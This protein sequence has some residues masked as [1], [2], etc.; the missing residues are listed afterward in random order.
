MIISR[1]NLTLDPFQL[2]MHLSIVICENWMYLFSQHMFE[3]N[4][5]HFTLN[6]DKIVVWK[7][8][9]NDRKNKFFLQD[10]QIAQIVGAT[11]IW[12]DTQFAHQ[13]SW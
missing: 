2:H 1:D 9:L 13:L 12:N 8:I 10:D 6:K 4:L 3:F 5:G 11:S 7:W